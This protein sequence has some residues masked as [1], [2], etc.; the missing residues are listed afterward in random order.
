MSHFIATCT[1]ENFG[2]H[3]NEI[4]KEEIASLLKQDN[5]W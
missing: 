4:Y 5:D 3:V 2:N 1:I